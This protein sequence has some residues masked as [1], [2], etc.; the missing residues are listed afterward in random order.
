MQAGHTGEGERAVRE[1]IASGIYGTKKIRYVDEWLRQK[2]EEKKDAN[3]AREELRD[4]ELITIARE[5][6]DIAMQ[7]R[8]EAESANS[9]AESALSETKKSTQ[10]ALSAKNAAWVAAIAAI[11]S[12]ILAAI[13]IY[14]N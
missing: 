14:L 6:N 7:A 12:V 10:T 4:N 1:R 3:I 8:D 9:I 2:E 5:A 13:A 11:T